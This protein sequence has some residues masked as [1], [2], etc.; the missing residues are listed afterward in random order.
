MTLGDAPRARGKTSGSVL[1]LGTVTVLPNTTLS[2]IINTLRYTTSRGSLSP[3]FRIVR[4]IVLYGQWLTNC[5][6]VGVPLARPPVSARPSRLGF[7]PWTVRSVLIRVI[8][9]SA[10]FPSARSLT[11]VLSQ[12]GLYS[13]SHFASTAGLNLGM[14][15]CYIC[16]SFPSQGTE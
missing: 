2:L 15:Q 8:A 11:R 3:K 1:T 14:E 16:S 9:F 4:P 12:G 6:G 7:A 13:G 5:E 10:C